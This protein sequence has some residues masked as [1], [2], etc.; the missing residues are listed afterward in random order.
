MAIAL[1]LLVEIF[2][3]LQRAVNWLGGVSDAQAGAGDASG[4]AHTGG[5]RG[6]SQGLPQGQPQAQEPQR[7]QPQRLWGGP[8]RIHPTRRAARVRSGRGMTHHA[9]W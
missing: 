2:D 9:R 1:S 4:A 5:S 3:L 7:T 8:L 6:S